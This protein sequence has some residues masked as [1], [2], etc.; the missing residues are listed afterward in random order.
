MSYG[1]CD[2]GCLYGDARGQVRVICRGWGCLQRQRC[3]WWRC[4]RGRVVGEQGL[5]GLLSRLPTMDL[6][7]NHSSA[8]LGDVTVFSC[9]LESNIRHH[10]AP[11][12]GM[13]VTSVRMH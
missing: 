2:G 1:T 13:P 3:G 10:G 12:S 4:S 8:T 6:A 11:K 5:G 7:S 9:W